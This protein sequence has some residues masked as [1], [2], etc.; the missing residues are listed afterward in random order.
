MLCEKNFTSQKVFDVIPKISPVGA[1]LMV[2]TYS[3]YRGNK[4]GPSLIRT[5][6]QKTI[7]YY[8]TVSDHFL[9][10]TIYESKYSL[11]DCQLWF[12]IEVKMPGDLY[13]F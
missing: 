4:S 11:L 12:E 2:Y 10:F 3:G 9:V 7:C 5:D 6:K 1:R 8:L 13:I